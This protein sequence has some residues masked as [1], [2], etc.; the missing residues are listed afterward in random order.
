MIIVQLKGGLGEPIISICD[1]LSLASHHGVPL[2]VDIV[3]LFEKTR[4]Q[5]QR[6]HFDLEK[7]QLQSGSSKWSWDCICIIVICFK[8]MVDKLKTCYKGG[9]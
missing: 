5:T 2:K 3:E 7:F 6:V 9:L 4:H 1:G 8:K